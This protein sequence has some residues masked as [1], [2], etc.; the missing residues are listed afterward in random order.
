M[1]VSVMSEGTTPLARL[2]KLRN[3]LWANVRAKTLTASMSAL[4]Q[5]LGSRLLSSSALG[6]CG[7][8]VVRTSDSPLRTSYFVH[9]T[10]LQVN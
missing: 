2:P 4:Q 5:A 1:S 10:L 3:K 6:A 7:G 8:K 9:C